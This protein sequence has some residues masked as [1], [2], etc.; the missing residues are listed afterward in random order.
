VVMSNHICRI[1]AVD[2]IASSPTFATCL[3]PCP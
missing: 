2:N 1:V 3:I